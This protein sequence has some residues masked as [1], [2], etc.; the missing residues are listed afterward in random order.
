[1]KLEVYGWKFREKKSLF[2]IGL[3]ITADKIGIGLGF[4][5]I[6]LVF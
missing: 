4:Y 5:M 3:D 6:L 1:M 2:S